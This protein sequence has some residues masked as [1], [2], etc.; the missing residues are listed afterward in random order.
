MQIGFHSS[1]QRVSSG[2][3]WKTVESIEAIVVR[4]NRVMREKLAANYGCVCVC[5]W[6][7]GDVW[8]NMDLKMLIEER[9]YD[10]RKWVSM[11]VCI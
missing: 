10:N 4:W 1:K 7:C 2:V 5:V 6:V 9:I 3:Q 8:E 11:W